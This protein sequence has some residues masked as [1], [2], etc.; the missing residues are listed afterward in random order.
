ML[1]TTSR[2][3]RRRRGTCIGVVLPVRVV[4]VRITPRGVGGRTGWWYYGLRG[5]ALA[6]AV[7]LV[8]GGL[9]IARQR[10]LVEASCRQL[11]ARFGKVV[12]EGDQAALV[13][14]GIRER[15]AVAPMKIL[16]SLE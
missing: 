3:R 8:T 10:Q 2:G 9:E 1:T 4:P 15:G 5:Q 12:A 7:A 14:L 11:L 6:Q 16:I 13:V